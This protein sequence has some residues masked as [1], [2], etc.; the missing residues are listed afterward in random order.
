MTKYVVFD[1]TALFF[2]E[3]TEKGIF[4][5]QKIFLRNYQLLDL[6][7]EIRK[8]LRNSQEIYLNSETLDAFEFLKQL[9]VL[10][11][12]TDKSLITEI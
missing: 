9:R 1:T 3:E 10:D 2:I 6:K 4:K 8:L 11:I 12:E 5:S 7:Y